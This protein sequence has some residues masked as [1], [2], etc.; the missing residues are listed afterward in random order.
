MTDATTD[1]EDDEVKV[2]QN[3]ATVADLFS[4]AAWLLK[5]GHVEEGRQHMKAAK[6]ALARAGGDRTKLLG[7]VCDQANQ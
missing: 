5:K 7:D 3:Y 6:V 1:D 4:H 2:D